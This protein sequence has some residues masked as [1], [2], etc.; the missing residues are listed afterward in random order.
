MHWQTHLLLLVSEESGCRRCRAALGSSGRSARSYA[1]ANRACG[2]RSFW[3]PCQQWQRAGLCRA[4][5]IEKQLS[6]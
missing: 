5:R 2:S 1:R 4:S 3:R 6:M